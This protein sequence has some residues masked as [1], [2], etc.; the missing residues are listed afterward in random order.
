LVCFTGGMI[1]VVLVTLGRSSYRTAV[2]RAASWGEG[3]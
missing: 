2:Q 3:V 1:G